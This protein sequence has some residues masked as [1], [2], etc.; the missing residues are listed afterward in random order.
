M[1]QKAERLAYPLT[2]VF[3]Q[4]GDQWSALACEVDVA[5]CG[6]T[7]DEAREGLKDAVELYISYML[8]NGLR[9]QV[10]RPVPPQDWV[11]FCGKSQ[12]TIE[13]HTLILDLLCAGPTPQLSEIAFVRS[14]VTPAYCGRYALAGR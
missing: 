2:F 8:E 7:I 14:E 4:E 6:E 11:E 13:Y 10:A 12:P 1:G 5:S 9:H 3:M